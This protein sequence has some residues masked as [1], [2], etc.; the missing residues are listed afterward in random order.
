MIKINGKEVPEAEGRILAEF[1]KESGFDIKRI[2]VECDGNIIPKKEY[3]NKVIFD[4]EI[5]EIVSFVGGG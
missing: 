1:L 4:G 5:I 3:D 2:A